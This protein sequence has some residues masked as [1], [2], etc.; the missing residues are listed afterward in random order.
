[1]QYR[2]DLI[3]IFNN[4]KFS[5]RHYARGNLSVAPGKKTSMPVNRI[6]LEAGKLYYIPAF[7]PVE[8]YLDESLY[9]LSIHNNFEIFPG[10][11]LFSGC[12]RMT[13]TD[14]PPQITILLQIMDTE[15]E[16]KFLMSL[17]AGSLILSLQS[18]LLSFYSPEDFHTPL[19]LQNYAP[20]LEYLEQ[21]GSGRTTVKDLA[22]FRNE[23]RENFTRHFT[24]TTKMTPKQLID[25]VVMGKALELL[26]S[27]HSVKETADILEFSNEFVFSRAFKRHTGSSPLIWLKQ[28][29][30]HFLP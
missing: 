1:M 16:K 8:F 26:K 3:R 4:A 22:E 10:V 13:V 20:L 28:N 17:R 27:G 18:F 21:N 6:I 9:F 25:N 11:E 5:L 12:P 7:L 14:A 30:D 15:E 2:T 23:S 24:G 29:K 19:A